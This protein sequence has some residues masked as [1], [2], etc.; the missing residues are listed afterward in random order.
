MSKHTAGPMCL[1]NYNGYTNYG[2]WAVCLWINNDEPS[3]QYWEGRA[4]DLSREELANELLVSL[5]ECAW[6]ALG[7]TATLWADLLGWVLD[8]VDWFEVAD[9]LREPLGS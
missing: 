4:A 8:T 5:S 3:Q 6:E 1:L 2:T 7:D 9:M